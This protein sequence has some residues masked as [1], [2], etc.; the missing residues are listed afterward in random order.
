MEEIDLYLL[1]FV[2]FTIKVVLILYNELQ[3]VPSSLCCVLC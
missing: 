3:R 2:L 1:F